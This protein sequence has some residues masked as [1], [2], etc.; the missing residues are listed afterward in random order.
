MTN[1]REKKYMCHQCNYSAL[2]RRCGLDNTPNRISVM[3]I[4]GNSTYPL[5]VQEVFDILKRTKHVNRVTVYRVLDILV[6]KGL[7]E[8]I[9]GGDRAFR[10]GIAPNDNHRRHPHFYCK[11]CGNME[12]LNPESISVDME[13]LERTFSGLIEKAEVRIDGVCRNCLRAEKK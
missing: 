1:D 12:C 9:S 4:V 7:L 3:E 13:A 2:F 10:Y 5:S 6:K 8:R 11:Q